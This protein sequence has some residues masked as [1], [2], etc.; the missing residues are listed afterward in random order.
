M[1]YKVY[2]Q[3]FRDA[4]IQKYLD[5]VSA[6]I[7]AKECGAS[8]PSII[9]WLR[10][11][12]VSIRNKPINTLYASE[13]P[14]ETQDEI[15]KLYLNNKRVNEIANIVF[16][17]RTLILKILRNKNISIRSNSIECRRI[18]VNEEYFNE[19]N[20]ERKAYFLG[21]L[22]A[23][24]CV[25]KDGCVSISLS[26]EEDKH[27]LDEFI[28]DI[29]PNK[30]MEFLFPK[31]GHKAYRVSLRREKLVNSLIKLGCIPRKSLK[32]KSI[33]NISSSLIRHFIRGYFDGD[34]CI[35]KN[36]KGMSV[37]IVGTKKF[38]KEIKDRLGEAEIIS[39]I[40][41]TSSKSGKTFV[42]KFGS[43]KSI[44]LFYDLLYKD[45]SIFLIRKKN[46]FNY[47]YE[48]RA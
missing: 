22:Y 41:K 27:I 44:D 45:T 2:E 8:V 24:G 19:I 28:K 47:L 5:G 40:Y 18:S 31:G 30:K 26:G 16:I 36:K 10:K 3:S 37:S 12:G 15:V 29:C 13:I 9:N 38:L 39:F 23:D 42:L 17:S 48:N 20:N 33:P 21:L 46:K 7:I 11:A 1:D 25:S 34:G 6:N 43:K 14:E 35:T 32:L 4:A